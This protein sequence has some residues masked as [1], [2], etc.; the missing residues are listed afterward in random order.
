MWAADIPVGSGGTFVVSNTTGGVDVAFD[1]NGYIVDTK[2]DSKIDNLSG[3][4]TMF[5]SGLTASDW[6]AS[7]SAAESFS[8]DIESTPLTSGVPEPSTG[9]VMIVGIGLVGLRCAIGVAGRRSRPDRSDLR[10]GSLQLD[11][12]GDPAG[13]LTLEH[14]TAVTVTRLFVRRTA[15]ADGEAV[16]EEAAP[17]R[18]R[19]TRLRALLTGIVSYADGAVSFQLRHS[20]AV[21]WRRAASTAEGPHR[22]G[23]FLAH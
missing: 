4:F 20:R 16:D 14:Q 19:A 7:L 2:T 9:G 8:A 13:G 17:G 22:S 11:R 6:S 1:V 3:V 12:V 21:R 23:S 18:R 15:M 10:P 5:F